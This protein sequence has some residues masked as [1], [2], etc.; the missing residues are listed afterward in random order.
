[1]NGQK[2][3]TISNWGSQLSNDVQHTWVEYTVDLLSPPD[4]PPSHLPQ[5][6]QKTEMRK[7]SL[8]RHVLLKILHIRQKNTWTIA[9]YLCNTHRA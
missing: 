3:G 6:L 1:M 9:L 2:N 8:F 7:D 5:P 4:P